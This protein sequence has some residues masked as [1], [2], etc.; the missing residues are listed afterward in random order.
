MRPLLVAEDRNRKVSN[1]EFDYYRCRV[2]GVISLLPVPIDLGRYYP[3]DYID[4]RQDPVER[5]LRSQAERYKLRLLLRVARGGR[6]LEIG[7]GAGGFLELAQSAGFEVEAIEQDGETCRYLERTL[8]ARTYC[9][10][11]PASAVREAGPYAVIA[12]WHSLEHLTEPGDVLSAA[13][14][15]LVP[16]GTVMVAT[17][18]PNALQFRVFRSRWT[19]LD[20]PRHLHLIP[21]D[22]VREHAARFGLR[23]CTLLFS[24]E[25]TRNWNAFGWRN[26]LR[27]SVP[28]GLANPAYT[29]GRVIGRLSKPVER[30]GMRASTYTAILQQ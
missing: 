8:G 3:S 19:H 25:G 21:P 18:N 15:A 10:S 24:D 9:T 27:N 11:D 13:A 28:P 1:T 26:S 6:L 30:R 20:S 12:L 29:T 22:V 14:G 17:P 16:G 7:P 23:R 4:Q 5:A 2:C